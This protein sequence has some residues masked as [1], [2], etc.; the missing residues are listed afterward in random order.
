L[1]PLVARSADEYREPFVGSG[2]I[3]L[4]VMSHLPQLSYWLNDRDP[5]MACLWFAVRHYGPELVKRVES[6]TPTI[7]AFRDFKA[8][9]DAL[10]RPPNEPKEIVEIGFRK[11]ALHQSSHSGFGGGVL[12]GLQQDAFEKIT[13][14]WSSG[15]IAKNLLII[16]N[17]LWRCRTQI[18]AFDFSRLIEDT[19]RRACLYLD[20]PYLGTRFSYHEFR[21]TPADH[22]RLA[23]ML[24]DAPHRFALSY[25]DHP[26]IRRLYDWAEI[27][28]IG[29]QELLIIGK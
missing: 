7:Q 6:F 19:S 13:S 10:V 20:P 29:E 2:A 3:G 11:L 23:G 9:L 4:S 1:L 25:R 5:G 16:H 26:T 18:T 15:L 27:V 21:F 8:N 24:R 22:D 14:R 28:E 12:G 17:R